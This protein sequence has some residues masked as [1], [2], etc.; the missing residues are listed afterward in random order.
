MQD[1]DLQSGKL[2]QIPVDLEKLVANQPGTNIIY[3]SQD[4]HSKPVFQTW[5]FKSQNAGM[6]IDCRITEPNVISE[7]RDRGMRAVEKIEVDQKYLNMA[8][9]IISEAAKYG[10]SEVHLNMKGGFSTVQFEIDGELRHYRF[11]SVEDSPYLSRAIYQGLAG[12]KEGWWQS[13]AYQDAQIPDEKLPQGYGLTSARL[14]R[15]PAWPVAKGGGFITIRVQAEGTHTP[16][17]RKGLKKLDYPEGPKG[18]FPYR[19]DNPQCRLTET[20]LDKLDRMMSFTNGGIIFTGPTA[21]GKTRLMWECLAQKAREQPWRRQVWVEDPNELPAPWAV[22]MYVPGSRNEE[23]NGESFAEAARTSLRMAPKTIMFSELRGK[24]VARAF[25]WA[26][27]TGHDGWTSV[28]ANDPF[29]APSR[30]EMLDPVSL[31][32]A[33]FC[34]PDTIRAYVGVRLIPLLC[35]ACKVSLTDKPTGVK[36][37]ILRD[38]KTWGGVDGVYLR[39]GGCPKCSFSGSLGRQLIMEIVLNDEELAKDFIEHGTTIARRNYRRRRSDAC[40]ALLDQ[41]IALVLSGEA[42]PAS[43]EDKVGP[44]RPKDVDPGVQ[45]ALRAVDRIEEVVHV[46]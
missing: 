9:E 1:N 2:L 12:T 28:H 6:P 10:A 34:D 24:T 20:Q 13:L 37:R 11:V 36:P 19:S 18:D 46:A 22:Q 40:P 4:V 42:D 39:G 35:D 16:E 41:S 32:K 45:A 38:L 14:V 27:Q 29:Q 23:D 31:H 5:L 8:S 17:S 15:G 3:V 33:S 21:N 30:I 44:M 25:F 26:C 7:M 43:I